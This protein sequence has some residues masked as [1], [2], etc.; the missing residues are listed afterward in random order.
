MIPIKPQTAVQG[1]R[2]AR[3]CGVLAAKFIANFAQFSAKYERK[4]PRKKPVLTHLYLCGSD[5]LG[6]FQALGKNFEL[7]FILGSNLK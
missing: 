3:C 4:L 6:H 5:A 1:P 2:V 7:I